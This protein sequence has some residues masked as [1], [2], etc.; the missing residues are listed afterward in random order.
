MVYVTV[1]SP[2]IASNIRFPAPL[3]NPVTPVVPDPTQVKVVPTLP[4]D[5]DM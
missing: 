1:P 5:K 4:P 2:V 3:E